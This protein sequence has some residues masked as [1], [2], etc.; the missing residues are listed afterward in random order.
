MAN[1]TVVGFSGNFRRPSRT[2]A[3]V[4][5]I[6]LETSQTHGLTAE[7]FDLGDL[8]PSLGSARQFS[9]LAPP[10]RAIAEKIIS[11][12]ILVVG[13][14]TYK[15]SYAGLF[16]HFL[17]LIDP[18]ALKGKPVLLAATGG[19]ERH[20]LIIEHH[21]RPLF[22]FFMAHTLPTGVYAA[23][24]DF[25]GEEI[26]APNIHARIAQAVGEVAPFVTP[27]PEFALNAAE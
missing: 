3:L 2:R 8:E 21:L 7:I 4:E 27:V 24:G 15:G 11:A 1:S 10:A 26:S 25:A 20:A 16:K 14:P 22:S 6:V 18:M 17:D 12:Q 23:P 19:S 5:R 13:S 9:D